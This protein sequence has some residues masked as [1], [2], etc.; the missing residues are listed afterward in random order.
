MA[1]AI[2]IALMV[3]A[4]AAKQRA[5]QQKA[6]AAYDET[7]RQIAEQ[8]KIQDQANQ[9][10]A[11]AINELDP[12]ARINSANQAFNGAAQP[13]VAQAAAAASAAH[14]GGGSTGESASTSAGNQAALRSKLSA[15]G[16]ANGQTTSQLDKW[17][18]NRSRLQQIAD[19][20][21]RLYPMETE[22]AA[23][24]AGNGWDN[25]ST[26]LSLGG[27]GVGAYNSYSSGAK[28]TAASPTYDTP[29]TNAADYK[30]GTGN[31]P[32]DYRYNGYNR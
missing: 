14:V 11:N 3:A 13:A 30:L 9:D 28:A 20:R 26:V 2:P 12:N 15:L 25:T 17:G 31:S 19:Q 23:A 7:Q 32:Y 6:D 4:A 10:S 21:A 1:A 22:Q 27:A 5:N 16:T 29:G 18:R 24:G 8:Y